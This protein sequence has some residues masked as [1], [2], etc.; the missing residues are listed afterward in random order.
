MKTTNNNPK[1]KE[2]LLEMQDQ[3]Y[4]LLKLIEEQHIDFNELGKKMNSN[5]ITIMQEIADLRNEGEHTYAHMAI[6]LN[7]YNLM[8]DAMLKESRQ[9]YQRRFDLILKN[10]ELIKSLL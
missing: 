9:A 7:G 3:I 5:L 2:I 6:K 10:Y 8:S 4:D 1:L